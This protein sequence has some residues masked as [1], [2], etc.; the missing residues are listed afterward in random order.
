M[1]KI[2]L[3]LFAEGADGA[4]SVASA[5]EEASENAETFEESESKEENTP[6]TDGGEEKKAFSELIKNEY[7]DE[8]TEE[9]NR[10]FS[11]RYKSEQGFRQKY[12]ALQEKFLPLM[13]RFDAK[14][15]EEL[16]TKLSEDEK[17]LAEEAMEH[18]MDAE[19]YKKFL[20]LK[21]ENRRK[22]EYIERIE[23]ERAEAERARFHNE[24]M[25]KWYSEAEGVKEE[26]PDFDLSDEVKNQSFLAALR[27]GVSLKDAYRIAHPDVYKKQIAQSE[28][29]AALR[30]IQ[31]RS[32]R[33]TENGTGGKNAAREIKKVESLTDGEIEEIRRRVISG[34]K[35]SFS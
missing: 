5:S 9:V 3:Q 11:K 10:I 22:T 29:Q 32:A 2:Y 17:R 34:E 33:P 28:R 15:P 27:M 13:E 25:T 4:S 20:E 23:Q 12:E 6:Q 24:Q 8:F 19:D 26:Y 7:K 16:F 14:T 35:I 18:G 21:T 31:E 1:E 30:A